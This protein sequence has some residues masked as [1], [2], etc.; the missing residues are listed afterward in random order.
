MPE[1]KFLILWPCFLAVVI[2]CWLFS[3]FLTSV[4]VVG[5]VEPCWRVRWA[6]FVRVGYFWG[7]AAGMLQ[8]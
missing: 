8:W 7:F 1:L 4:E 3:F 6:E 5:T 2:F